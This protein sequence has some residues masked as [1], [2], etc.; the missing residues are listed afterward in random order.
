MSVTPMR[1]VIMRALE[2]FRFAI[3]RKT[4]SLAALLVYEPTGEIP[5]A[6]QQKLQ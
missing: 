4:A 3:A 1:S 2:R 5:C 6:S